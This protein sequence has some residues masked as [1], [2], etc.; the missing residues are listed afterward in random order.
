[1]HHQHHQHHQ[2]HHHHHAHMGN[3]DYGNYSIGDYTPPGATQNYSG[4]YFCALNKPPKF[5]RFY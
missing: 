1:M 5:E 4:Y 3:Y 2:H